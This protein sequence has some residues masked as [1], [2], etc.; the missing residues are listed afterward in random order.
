M[1]PLVISSTKAVNHERKFLNKIRFLPKALVGTSSCHLLELLKGLLFYIPY[2]VSF[3]EE[4]ARERK[5]VRERKHKQDVQ[6]IQFITYLRRIFRINMS[7]IY[8]QEPP[9]SGKVL[10]KTTVGEI[11]I[12]LWS[13]E[14]PKGCRNFLQFCLNQRYNKTLFHRLVPNFIVQ[15]GEN[16]HLPAHAPISRVETHSRLR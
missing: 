12:E 3:S 6:L 13:K 1:E 4:R 7:N 9:T 5:S 11:E 14:S 16:T 10:L 2:L 8:I 15:C